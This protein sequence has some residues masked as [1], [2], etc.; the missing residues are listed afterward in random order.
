MFA[1]SGTVYEIF[2]VKICMILTLTFRM[3]KGQM[4]IESECDTFDFIVIE[5]FV[6]LVTFMRY[7]H[8]NFARLIDRDLGQGQT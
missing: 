1:V 6:L 4:P 2:A 5:M 8:S 7:S 3:G